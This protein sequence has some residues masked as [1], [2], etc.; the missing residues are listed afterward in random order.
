MYVHVQMPR[1]KW[2]LPAFLKFSEIYDVGIYGLEFE[3]FSSCFKNWEH[4]F[5]ISFLNV[6]CMEKPVI[7]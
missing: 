5:S 2:G 1:E 4:R 3:S 7:Y 6:L